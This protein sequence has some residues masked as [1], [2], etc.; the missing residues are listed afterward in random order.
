MV[1][2]RFD[3][4]WIVPC[5]TDQATFDQLCAFPLASAGGGS[6]K[7]SSVPAGQTSVK[8]ACNAGGMIVRIGIVTE[9][10]ASHVELSR[11]CT[12]TTSGWPL[13]SPWTMAPVGPDHCNV[14]CCTVHCASAQL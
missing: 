12:E 13:P 7:T 9:V 8:C 2:P 3:D 4:H 11:T 1:A 5:W 10:S 14:P 6:R